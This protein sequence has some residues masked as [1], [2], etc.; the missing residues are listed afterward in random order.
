MRKVFVSVYECEPGMMMA[1]TIFNEYGAVI[2]AENAILDTHLI[3]KLDNLGFLQVKI[4]DQISNLITAS[5]SEIF[6]VQYNDN[7]DVVKDIL[8]E[9]SADKKIN[10]ESV[11]NVSDSI[12]MRLNE[13][14]DIVGCLNQIRGVDD[15]TYAHSVNVSLLSM[16]IGK[17]LKFDPNKIKLLVQAGLLHDIGK[18]KVPSDIINKPGKLTHDEF[19]EIKKHPLY[20]YRV[21]EGIDKISKD[22]CMGVLM[23]HERDDGSGYPLGAK[24]PQI[25][26]FAKI[27]AIADIYDAM[28]SARSYREKGSPFEVFELMENNAFGVLDPKAV[29]TFLTNIASYY[30]GDFVRLN[31][32]EIGEII[33]INSR[34]ISQPVI[35]VGNRYLDLTL[36]TKIKIVELI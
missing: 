14:R 36:D 23:H 22:V 33:Y 35:K 18:S 2:V 11:N 10:V 25:H 30:I 8:H 16:L 12:F 24:A 5:S 21:L 32:N 27:I 1:E 17:W 28:T 15:Y 31:T 19:E 34:H 20:G 26:E 4:Y 6:K 13:N 7:V 29:T 3:R 9:I